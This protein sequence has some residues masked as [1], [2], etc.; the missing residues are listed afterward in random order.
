MDGGKFQLNKERDLLVKAEVMAGADDPDIK[1]SGMSMLRQLSEGPFAREAGEL[2]RRYSEEPLVH[3]DRE[4]LQ[5]GDVLAPIERLTDARLLP[6]I[7][8]AKSNSRLATQ[9]RHGFVAKLRELI[10]LTSRRA[11]QEYDENDIAHFRMVVEAVRGIEIYEAELHPSLVELR[12][13]E[14]KFRLHH[15]RPDI[16][17]AMRETGD[18]SKAWELLDLVGAYDDPGPA[19][20]DPGGVAELMRWVERLKVEISRVQCA[21]RDAESLSKRA[22]LLPAAVGSW[23]QAKMALRFYEEVGQ[24][25]KDGRPPEKHRDALTPAVARSRS[26]VRA[27]VESQAR[28][29]ATFNELRLYWENYLSLPE[30]AQE[31]EVSADWFEPFERGLRRR[32]Q[33]LVAAATSPED[34]GRCRDDLEHES[35]GPAPKPHFIST[36]LGELDQLIKSWETM[37]GGGVFTPPAGLEPPARYAEES[38]EFGALLERVARAFERLNGSDGTDG[39]AAV[40]EVRDEAA[41]ILDQF[42]GHA[43]ALELKKAAELKAVGSNIKRAVRRWDVEELARLV[44]SA[45]DFKD[46]CFYSRNLETLRAIKLLTQRPAFAGWESAAGWWAEW[47]G[48]KKYLLM[49]RPAIIAEAFR[50]VEEARQSQWLGVLDGLKNSEL[51]ADESDRVADS[52]GVA[53]EG[54][55]LSGYQDLFRRKADVTRVEGAIK[56]GEW[57]AARELLKRLGKSSE[58]DRLDIVLKVAEAKAAGVSSWAKALSGLWGSIQRMADPSGSAAEAMLLEAVEAAWSRSEDD[59]LWNYLLPVMDRVVGDGAG[60]ETDSALLKSLRG[61]REWLQLEQGLFQPKAEHSL[62][63]LYRYTREEAAGD[64][65]FA[66]RQARLIDH[67]RAGQNPVP[68]IWAQVIW[69]RP[70]LADKPLDELT[71]ASREAA[72][73]VLDELAT[74]EDLSKPDITHFLDELLQKEIIF[75]RV[76]DALE[77]SGNQEGKARSPDSLTQALE[78]VKMLLEAMQTLDDSTRVDLRREPAAKEFSRVDLNL[79]THLRD[80]THIRAGLLA[81]V[82]RLEPL[83]KLQAIEDNIHEAAAACGRDDSASNNNLFDVLRQELAALC[84]RFEKAELVGGEMWRAV[85]AEYC[86]VVFREACLLFDMP[87]PPDLRSLIE[88]VGRLHLEGLTFRE[89]MDAL[90]KQ[91]PGGGGGAGPRRPPGGGVRRVLQ[92]F[93]CSAPALAARLHLFRAGLRRARRREG[94]PQGGAAEAAG[95]G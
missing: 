83:T 95:L 21:V 85:S 16:D 86:K 23:A 35:S 87:D 36:L 2:I 62:K 93:P 32:T 51:D 88:E 26:A 81:Q 3:R 20:G 4:V 25:L 91:R 79:R 28:S 29:V 39:E 67:W 74:R 31:F 94:H 38:K 66:R 72:K 78:Q 75:H 18:V 49:E 80:M 92:A 82:N 55:D 48:E 1:A 69:G 52:L 40:R 10:Y 68:L 90:W 61:W 41:S 8:Q 30:A 57:D 54:L 34:L 58:S 47:L 60:R 15:D 84:E 43:R 42:P 59:A 33:E 46:G 7:K 53:T 44:E 71:C 37:R 22:E 6:L 64:P 5:F 19:N 63:S 50:S 11:V 12:A 76:R 45:P 17:R 13:V 77:L 70:A 56:A 89:Q 9:V 14:L 65:L 27:F 24:F 73:R